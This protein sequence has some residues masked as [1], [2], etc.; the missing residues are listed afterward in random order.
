MSATASRY[1]PIILYYSYY[2]SKMIYLKIAIF[3]AFPLL[4]CLFTIHVYGNSRFRNAWL[5][6]AYSDNCRLFVARLLSLLVIVFHIAYYA[7]FPMDKGI[8]ISSLYVFFSLASRQN[9]KLL[10]AIR[11]SEWGISV[12]ALTAMG[13]SF[14]HHSLSSAITLAM[15]LVAVCCLPS[16]VKKQKVQ[17]SETSNPKMS[18]L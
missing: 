5:A 1:S 7:L 2:S 14:L 9:L 6:L 18:D 12:L 11:K 16:R 15:I 4:L 10:M 17:T 13:I 3:L 8:M